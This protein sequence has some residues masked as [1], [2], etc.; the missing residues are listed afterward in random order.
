MNRTFSSETRIVWVDVCRLLCAFLIVLGHCSPIVAGDRVARLGEWFVSYLFFA[1]NAL[2][3]SR[4]FAFYVLA[5]AFIT[6]R[7]GVWMNG[8]RFFFLASSFLCWNV[9]GEII[10]HFALGTPRYAW[11]PSALFTAMGGVPFQHSAMGA[12]WF[13]KYLCIF[14]LFAPC[15]CRLSPPVRL[16]LA[17]FAILFGSAHFHWTGADDGLANEAVIGF[18]FF[19]IG[20]C[21]KEVGIARFAAGLGKA[22]PLIL[23]GGTAFSVLILLGQ[24]QV[25]VSTYAMR[26][27]L[28]VLFLFSVCLMAERF[29]PCFSARVA[30][31]GK[32][33]F[34]I[35]AYH[36][37]PI[38]ILEAHP[39]DL[40]GFSF[41]WPCLIFFVGLFLYVCIARFVPVLLPILCLEKRKK[42]AR[43]ICPPLF[44][45]NS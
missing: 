1:H 29:F 44:A 24:P 4:V 34:F 19:V 21:L 39:V 13:L 12:M 14:S 6:F 40:G 30:S 43:T 27:V 33:A 8:K 26:S 45:K 17:M 23:S 36:C 35:Y 15:L 9:L 31:M 22:A 20:T 25:P 7:S 18:G 16:S 5:G 37:I 32:A 28:G 41:L 10:F 2:G 3:D 42:P 38:A 11:E